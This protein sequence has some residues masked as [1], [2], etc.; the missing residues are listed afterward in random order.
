M[1][2]PRFL[3]I[4]TVLS[5]LLLKAALAHAD[6]SE[7]APEAPSSPPEA[8]SSPSEASPDPAPSP[9][10]STA[11]P[12][13]AAPQAPEKPAPESTEVTVVGT[14][15]RERRALR[16]SSAAASSS[17]TTTTTRSQSSAGARRLVRTETHG[18]APE[19]RLRGAN[20]DRSK[21]AAL[22]EDGVPF[23][24]RLLA[25]APITSDDCAHDSSG[26]IKGPQRSVWSAN[27]WRRDRSG[28]TTDSGRRAGSVDSRGPIRDNNSRLLWLER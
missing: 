13:E 5:L 8:P 24:P 7:R 6:P 17:D 22:M 18:S 20:P 14:R 1:Q 9:A 2:R 25:P 15:W 26:V 3:P 11:P 21:K 12:I 23:A 16:T 27:G 10:E 28:D 19:H 4:S